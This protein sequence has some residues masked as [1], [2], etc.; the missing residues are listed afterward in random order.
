MALRWRGA[1]RQFYLRTHPDLVTRHGPEIQKTN[2]ES[3][4]RLQSLLYERPREPVKLQFHVLSEDRLSLCGKVEAVYIPRHGTNNLHDA[5]IDKFLVKVFKDYV[6]PEL[7]PVMCDDGTLKQRPRDTKAD[8]FISVKDLFNDDEKIRDAIE[9]IW[10]WIPD[11][12]RT[13]REEIAFM[14]QNNRFQ[15]KNQ[16]DSKKAFALIFDVM[17]SLPRAAVSKIA[18]PAMEDIVFVISPLE[19]DETIFHGRIYHISS[20]LTAKAVVPRILK[21]IKLLENSY[22]N[23]VKELNINRKI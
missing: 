18:S 23:G 13:L 2:E 10:D 22:N 3:I 6:S 16:V 14:F 12:Y 4:K 9:D 1:I 17:H 20:N 7:L 19:K 11:S 21:L 15:V 5:D 8:P